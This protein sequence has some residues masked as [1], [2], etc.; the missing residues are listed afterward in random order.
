[1]NF[2]FKPYPVLTI[3]SLPLLFG[4]L[5][6][7]DWQLKRHEWKQKLFYQLKKAELEEYHTLSELEKRYKKGE[8][9]DYFPVLI[10]KKCKTNNMNFD[11][12]FVYQAKNGISWRVLDWYINQT[13][14]KYNKA[15]LNEE[16]SQKS[17]ISENQA[18]LIDYGLVSETYRKAYVQHLNKIKKDSFL[19]GK[20]KS[21]SSQENTYAPLIQKKEEEGSKKY[22]LSDQEIPDIVSNIHHMCGILKGR[23]WPYHSYDWFTPKGDGK[24]N[25]WYRVNLSYFSLNNYSF[26]VSIKR[27]APYYIRLDQDHFLTWMKQHNNAMRRE[28]INV[29]N[30]HV[31]NSHYNALPK[32]HNRHLGYA[33]TWFGFAILL[34][35]FYILYHI[36][37]KRFWL[38]FKQERKEG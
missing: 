5:W 4:L 27:I 30:S 26:P 23:I 22:F 19:K 31:Q 38:T 29:Q 3:I 9:I 33:I 15:F 20:K 11:P 16:L 18:F 6:L 21:D 35:V 34:V 1:M 36:S 12:M 17:S 7:G 28:P 24:K 8:N 13:E 37:K 10:D 14:K 25:L 32:F 2:I